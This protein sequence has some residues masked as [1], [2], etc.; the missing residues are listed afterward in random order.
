MVLSFCSH[1]PPVHWMWAKKPSQRRRWDVSISK[2]FIGVAAAAVI[3]TGSLAG[4]ALAQASSN[5]T[6]RQS[7][8]ATAI[9]DRDRLQDGSCDGTPDQDRIRLGDQTIGDMTVTVAD[10]STQMRIRTQEQT[11]AQV[12]TESVTRTQTQT[13]TQTQT[14]TQTEAGSAA[15]ATSCDST[16]DGTPDRVRDQDR[17]R[18]GSGDG[19]GTSSQSRTGR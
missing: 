13:G 15:Q 3:A 9:Q 2:F 5:T 1:A 4:S 16:C 19:A 10:A 8:S 14:R 12:Q 11:Q 17:L 7:P 6:D 18:D